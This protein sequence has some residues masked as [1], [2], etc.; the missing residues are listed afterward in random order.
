MP[1]NYVRVE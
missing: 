1:A